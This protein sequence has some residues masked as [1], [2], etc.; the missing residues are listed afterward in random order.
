MFLKKKLFKNNKMEKKGMTKE[1]TEEDNTIIM[2]DEYLSESGAQGG[3]IIG[4][5]LA[6]GS[7]I[8][9][10]PLLIIG[11]Y[12]LCSMIF[13]FGFPTNTAVIILTFLVTVIGLLLVIGGYS[14]YRDK[15]VKN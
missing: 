13:G 14:I 12:A 4:E 1:K 7:F 9:G 6:L 11:L 5:K 2:S 3:K 8:I 10:I 15:H